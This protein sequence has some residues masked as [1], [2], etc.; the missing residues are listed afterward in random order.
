MI[1]SFLLNLLSAKTYY[2]NAYYLVGVLVLYLAQGYILS[3]IFLQ[4]NEKAWK[5]YIPYYNNYLLFKLFWKARYYFIVLFLSIL[6]VFLNSFGIL[7]LASSA[8]TQMV[9]LGEYSVMLYFFVITGISILST[10]LSIIIHFVLY[11]KI[12]KE[13]GKKWIYALLLCISFIIFGFLLTRSKKENID[14]EIIE[15]EV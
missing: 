7:L 5:G 15:P 4:K 9:T 14:V 8:W 3:E 1:E 6:P 11:K 10:I 2:F 13:Y 12:A